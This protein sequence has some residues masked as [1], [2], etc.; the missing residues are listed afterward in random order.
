MT[1][2]AI[3]RLCERLETNH[4]GPGRRS[5][6]YIPSPINPDGPEAAALIR[7]QAERV[8]ALEWA[9]ERIAH[10]EYGLGFNKLRGIARAAINPTGEA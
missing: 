2:A 9:L 7:S 6:G 5:D 1:D 4:P 10:P 8:K 3:E